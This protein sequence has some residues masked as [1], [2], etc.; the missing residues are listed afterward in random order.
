VTIH[1][2]RRRSVIISMIT[3]PLTALVACGSSVAGLRT[4]STSAGSTAIAGA[5]TSAPTSTSGSS[6][7]PSTS[8]SAGASSGGGVA[9][10]AAQTTKGIAYATVSASET[11]D[12][13]LPASDGTKAVPVVVLI[14]GGAF[15]MGDAGMEASHAQA[16]VAKGIAAV[17]VN[18]RLSGEA[19]FPAG[20]QDVKAAVRW[21]R[22]NAATY[23]L[24]P[25]KIGAWGESA[26][27]W[28]ANMLG[29]T[30]D[31]T[32]V[33][34]DPKLG[35]ADQSS[36]VQAVVSWF[37]PTNFAT[38]DAEANQTK[39][40]SPDVHGTADSPE[41]IWLGEAVATSAKAQQTDLAAYAA[42]AQTLPPWYLA[43]GDSDCQVTPGQS[44][45]LKAALEKKNVTVT[46]QILAGA[47]H[48][49]PVFEQTQLVPSVAF[50]AATLGA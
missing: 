35:N 14:H 36:A 32:T 27:G 18:Y 20:A 13:Y 43:H 44:A 11:L 49:D 22:A 15:K 10:T 2:I 34:D 45:E 48:A 37:G 4:T 21:L 31:Q 47:R 12:L 8:N 5:A 3:L 26:G 1:R 19:P 42:T 25:T 9:R 6:S 29:V 17:S 24:D 38:M 23:G 41:S 39:C 46:Y 50:L 30:G 28:M 16:L 33:F 40:T 7:A